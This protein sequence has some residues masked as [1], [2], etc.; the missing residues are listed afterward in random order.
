[1][2]KAVW[3][4]L[5]IVVAIVGWKLTSRGPDLT[6]A[7]AENL[8]E[9]T[10]AASPVVVSSE[11]S[12]PSSSPLASTV[13]P[14]DTPEERENV[15]T[16]K[17]LPLQDDTRRQAKLRAIALQN[18]NDP[19][20]PMRQKDF[21][22]NLLIAHKQT[23]K[24]GSWNMKPL[25]GDGTYDGLLETLDQRQLRILFRLTFDFVDPGESRL[26]LLPASLET[27]A[28]KR[29]FDYKTWKA[30]NPFREVYRG[31]MSFPQDEFWKRVSPNDRCD[32]ILWIID[33]WDIS[34]NDTYS[35]T[36]NAR[37]YCRV[38]QSESLKPIA[39]VG[40]CALSSDCD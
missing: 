5:V 8:S 37:V 15:V 30:P 6:P 22:K 14:T 29:T 40:M 21:D 27:A 16:S 12:P 20:A 36:F 11:P 7:P 38:G 25:L 33:S 3:T 39:Q 24:D 34:R 32:D 13:M 19:N 10:L 18:L 9:V 1:M 35:K 28:D 26:G 23:R 17:T 31:S 4:L 2:K